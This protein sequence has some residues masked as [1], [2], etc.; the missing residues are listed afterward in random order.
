MKKLSFFA[1]LLSA[2]VL[3]CPRAAAA[4]SVAAPTPSPA[5]VDWQAFLDAVSA[6]PPDNL[7]SLSSRELAQVVESHYAGEQSRGLAF[8][9]K[10]PTDPRRWIAVMRL[11]STQ[12][13]FV[14]EWG[15]DDRGSPKPVVDEAAAAAWKTRIEDLKAALPKATDLPAEVRD[16]L[17]LQH[18]MKPFTAAAAAQKNG[19]KLDLA[20]L[21]AKVVSFA[22]TYPGAASGAGL[23]NAY[24]RLVEKDEPDRVGAEW[25]FFTGSPSKA[26]ADLAATKSG[27]AALLQRPLEIA[28]TAVDGRAVDLKKL[29]GKVVLVDFWATW[30][31][32]CIAELPNVKRVYAAYHE[33]GFEVIGVSLENGSLT[34]KDT[35]EQTAAKLAKAKKILTDFTNAEKMPWPQ[36][37]D[38]RYWKNEISTRFGIASIPAM[39]LLDQEGRVVSTNARGEKLEAEVKRLLKL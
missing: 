17:L 37:F 14:K 9:D 13:R 8:I 22:N 32:P 10:H 15:V 2:A 34:P 6:R 30:C 4:E 23:I 25:A 24:V 21:R 7:T 19:Q 18:A 29:R 27:A 38:G 1:L 20:Y 5:D 36:H 3:S 33:K 31:G 12:P 11:N 26:I 28:F 39:F 16:Q 35:P